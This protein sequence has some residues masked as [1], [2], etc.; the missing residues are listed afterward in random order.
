MGKGEIMQIQS[1][2]GYSSIKFSGFVKT[3]KTFPVESLVNPTEEVL[4]Q[5]KIKWQKML[6]EMGLVVLKEVKLGLKSSSK[7]K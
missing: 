3:N 7:N 5:N 2:Q 4:K 6:E 1:I